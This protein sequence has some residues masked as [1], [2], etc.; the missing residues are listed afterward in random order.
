MVR[1]D[2]NE[3][4]RITRYLQ[5]NIFFDTTHPASRGKPQVECAIEVSGADHILFGTSFPVFYN[6][7]N[8]GVEFMKTLDITEDARKAIM[9][10]NAIK[11]FNPKV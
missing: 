4:E 3:G 6:W 9:S 5:N 8:G 11:M 2:M 1:L 10:E 7:M